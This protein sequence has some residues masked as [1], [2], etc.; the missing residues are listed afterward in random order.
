MISPE[1]EDRDAG[2]VESLIDAVLGR[3]APL[4]EREV[5]RLSADNPGLPPEA[6]ARLVVDRGVHRAARTSALTALPGGVTSAVGVPGVMALQVAMVHAVSCVFGEQASP[7]ARRDL[8]VVLVG[9]R[10]LE[11]MDALGMPVPDRLRRLDVDARVGRAEEP[12]LRRALASLAFRWAR[13]RAVRSAGRALPLVGAAVAYRSDRAATREI[14][15][16]A[17]RYYASA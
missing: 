12:R 6:L 5:A 7:S 17:L 4:V 14:G 15:E 3:A 13:R 9:D 2:R 11:V 1:D 16:R 8:L 10:A